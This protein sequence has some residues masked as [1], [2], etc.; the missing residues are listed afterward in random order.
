MMTYCSRRSSASTEESAVEATTW[1]LWSTSFLSKE[2]SIIFINRAAALLKWHAT[3][4]KVCFEHSLQVI[5]GLNVLSVT[6]LGL[7]CNIQSNIQFLAN[8]LRLDGNG[9]CLQPSHGLVW[10]ETH[11][12]SMQNESLPIE[13]Q[14]TCFW[15]QVEGLEVVKSQ[16]DARSKPLPPEYFRFA[17][18]FAKALLSL[19]MDAAN[20]RVLFSKTSQIFGTFV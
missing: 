9:I 12:E 5:E 17:Y 6:S 19:F 20:F 14:R 18:D 8:T 7:P 11:F 15:R 3:S 13:E 4:Q 1:M 16:W 10:T 2:L